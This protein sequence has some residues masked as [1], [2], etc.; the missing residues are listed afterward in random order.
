MTEKYVYLG[1]TTYV[2]KDNIQVYL[3]DVYI[4]NGKNSDLLKI[5][6]NK[7]L[8]E[9]LEQNKFVDI[10]NY[11]SVEYNIFSKKYITKINL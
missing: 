6:V 3:A 10:T 8:I 11:I 5:L 1:Y 9:F 4:T 7:D 2:N